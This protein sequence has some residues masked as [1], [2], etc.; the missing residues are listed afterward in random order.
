MNGEIAALYQHG[1]QV[2]GVY[3]WNISLASD[4]TTVNGW[5]EYTFVKNIVATSYWLVEVPADECFEAKFYKVMQGR[6]ILM[7]EGIIEIAFPD[8]KTLNRRLDAPLEIIWRKHLE[9]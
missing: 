8:T 7:D 9:Y 4:S 3:N 5:R 2:G 6:L 1:Q